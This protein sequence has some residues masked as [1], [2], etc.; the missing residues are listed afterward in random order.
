LLVTSAL[1]L[2]NSESAGII[3]EASSLTAVTLHSQYPKFAFTAVVNARLTFHLPRVSFGN[4]GEI[5][6]HKATF[7]QKGSLRFERRGGDLFPQ[8]RFVEMIAQALH[9]FL[10]R[11]FLL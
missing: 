4:I 6:D 3:V 11:N 2:Y 9:H 5:D 8:A 10:E 1:W 7:S